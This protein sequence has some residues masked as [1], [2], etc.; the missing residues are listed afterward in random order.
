[1]KVPGFVACILTL[2]LY[3]AA[4]DRPA[5]ETVADPDM[6][7]TGGTIA[8]DPA[9]PGAADPFGAEDPAAPGAADQFGAQAPADEQRADLPGTASPLPLAGLIGLLS[10]GG[11]VGIRLFTSRR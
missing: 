3:A 6:T 5:D 1:M 9:A 4:C 2:S 7:G 8:E 11:A 10:L